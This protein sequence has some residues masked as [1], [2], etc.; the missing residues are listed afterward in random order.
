MKIPLKTIEEYEQD[1]EQS[2]QYYD[3]IKN[4]Q[5]VDWIEMIKIRLEVALWYRKRLKVWEQKPPHRWLLDY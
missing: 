1:L 3:Q 4:K 5:V 2:K